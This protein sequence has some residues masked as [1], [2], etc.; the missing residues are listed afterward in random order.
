[1]SEFSLEIIPEKYYK[2]RTE[3]ILTGLKKQMASVNWK[4]TTLES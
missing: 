2:E 4:G 3:E 1:M